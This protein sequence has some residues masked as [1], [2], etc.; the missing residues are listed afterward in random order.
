MLTKI[1]SYIEN[2]QIKIPVTTEY[3][4]TFMV[5]NEQEFMSYAFKYITCSRRKTIGL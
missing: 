4:Q 2:D 1:L 5:D 3:G